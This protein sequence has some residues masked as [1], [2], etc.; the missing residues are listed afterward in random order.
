MVGLSA[1]T[2][3]LIFAV[4][5]SQTDKDVLGLKSLL[6][7]NLRISIFCWQWLFKNHWA[8]TVYIYFFV[9]SDYLKAIE[10]PSRTELFNPAKFLIMIFKYL[11][12]TK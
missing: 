11:E 2:H 1:H 12:I 6:I 5:S 3:G 9:D 8:L 7:L 10:K 4:D